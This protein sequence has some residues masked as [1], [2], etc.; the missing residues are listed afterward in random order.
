MERRKRAQK[1]KEKLEVE[2]HK[3]ESAMHQRKITQYAKMKYQ[4]DPGTGNL[5]VSQ[6]A[7]QDIRVYFQNLNGVMGS[8][9]KFDNRRALLSLRDGE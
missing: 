1:V 7:K 9:T 4:A 3:K 5:I 8:D 6:K 2:Q